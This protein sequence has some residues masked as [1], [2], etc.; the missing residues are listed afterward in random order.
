MSPHGPALHLH[1]QIITALLQKAGTPYSSQD[2]RNIMDSVDGGNADFRTKLTGGKN[3]VPSLKIPRQNICQGLLKEIDGC[4]YYQ[5]TGYNFLVEFSPSSMNLRN[6]VLK[7]CRVWRRVHRGYRRRKRD[8]V[9]SNLHKLCNITGQSHTTRRVV[10]TCREGISHQNCTTKRGI[11][12][13][14][15]QMRSWKNYSM[16][17]RET[18]QCQGLLKN[19]WQRRELGKHSCWYRFSLRIFSRYSIASS[20]DP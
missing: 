6:V 10:W 3:R 13:G 16:P 17:W 5:V 15:T 14:G 18:F 20:S 1:R 2:L 8:L 7:F 4:K 9:T 19:Y 11:E 12:I